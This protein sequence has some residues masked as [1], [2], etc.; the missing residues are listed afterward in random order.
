MISFEQKRK[1]FK[2]YNDV[3]DI[4]DDI[5]DKYKIQETQSNN[6]ILSSIGGGY[7][8]TYHRNKSN[9]EFIKRK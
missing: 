3:D 2:I 9:Y 1:I 7:E 6:A 4:N 8:Q 5:N